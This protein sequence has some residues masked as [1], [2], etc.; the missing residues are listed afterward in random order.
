MKAKGESEWKVKVKSQNE[1]GKHYS[2]LADQYKF[3]IWKWRS[4]LQKCTFILVFEHSISIY[5]HIPQILAPQ[6]HLST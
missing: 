3:K 2:L 4:K 5:Q 1:K 6:V